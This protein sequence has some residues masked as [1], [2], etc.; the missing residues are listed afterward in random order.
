MAE[1]NDWLDG[2]SLEI[3]RGMQDEAA[4]KG[5][6]KG[7]PMGKISEAINRRTTPVAEPVKN[8]WNP[9]DGSTGMIGSNRY[10][11]TH[12]RSKR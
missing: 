6:S 3:L 1:S 4:D 5:Y 8:S 7:Y 12:S 11:A 9:I 2:L 10:G